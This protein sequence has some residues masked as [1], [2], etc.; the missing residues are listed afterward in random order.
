MHITIQISIS[1]TAVWVAS[2]PIMLGCMFLCSFA[3]DGQCLT[4]AF[5]VHTGS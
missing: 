1:P 5:P 3:S 2:Q 4:S